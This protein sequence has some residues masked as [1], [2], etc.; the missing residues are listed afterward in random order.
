MPVA[1]H[2]ATL[3]GHSWML[4][5]LPATQGMRVLTWLLDLLGAGAGS[6]ST[7]DL[8]E[9]DASQALAAV[10]GRLDSPRT[11]EI[12]QLLLRGLHEDGRPVDFDQRFAGDYGTLL[13]V[14]GWAL[15]VNLGGFFA[16]LGATPRP[17]GKGPA[18]R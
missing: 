15:E 14:V 16:E 5:S 11:I 4:N 2:E 3:A 7:Q 18:G 12:V 10:A 17:G 8:R 13:R 1:A 6:A 9:L